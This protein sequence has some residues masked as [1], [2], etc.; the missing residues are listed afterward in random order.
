MSGLFGFSTRA[1]EVMKKGK[2]LDVDESPSDVINRVLQTIFSV[3]KS[4]FHEKSTTS[5][6]ARKTFERYIKNKNVILGSPTLTNAGRKNHKNRALSSCVAIPVDLRKDISSIRKIIIPYYKQNMGSGFNF[7]DVED[8]VK[9]LNIL[10]DLSIA[11][12]ATQRYD[13]YIGNIGI[14]SIDHPKIEEFVE[15]KLVRDKFWHFNIS[16]NIHDAFVE[17]VK[18]NA[19]IV[20]KN[21]KKLQARKLWNKIITSVYHCGDPGLIFLDRMNFNNPLRELGAYTTTAPCAEVGL[22]PGEVCQFGYVNLFSF[23]NK[24]KQAIDYDQLKAVVMLLVRVL[25]DA[26]EYSSTVLPTVQSRNLI[27]AKRK[28][29]IGVCGFA[30]LLRVMNIP[31][32]SR[33]SCVILE[34]ILVF[35][36]YHSKVASHI[37]AQS[38]GSFGAFNVSDYSRYNYLEKRYGHIKTP[39]IKKKDWVLLGEKIKRSGLLR[40]VTTT[41]LPPSGRSAILLDASNSIEPYFSD[42]LHISPEKQLKIAH[43][44]AECV[45]ESVSKTFNVSQHYTHNAISSFF[46][47]ACDS[48]LKGVALYRNKSLKRQA[49]DL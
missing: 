25:D 38:R 42:V 43:V 49:I 28:I 14:L 9:I 33:K 29:G 34:E 27:K 46:L 17:A 36:N 13:R 30:D 47:C 6:I 45:D 4:V 26:I 15:S 24:N 21:G 18:H 22:I 40:N 31:Y 35:I 8:P 44:A 5:Q 32:G 7:D 48:A 1:I 39:H 10:N 11:E 3:E 16:I 41:A 23:Y 37:L 2:I 12:S 20:L 19:Y